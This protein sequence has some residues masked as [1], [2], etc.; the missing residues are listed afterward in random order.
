MTGLEVAKQR[1]WS[2]VSATKPSKHSQWHISP[3]ST[4][5]VVSKSQPWL[6]SSQGCSVGMCEGDIVGASL[7]GSNEGAVDGS[8]VGSCVGRSVGDEVN[9][10]LVS[11]YSS[12][13]KPSKHS[14]WHMSPSFTVIV[15]SKSQ[16]CEPV[17]QGCGV[18]MCVGVVVGATL[19]GANVGSELGSVDGCAVGSAVGLE[20]AT[21]CVVSLESIV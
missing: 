17:S 7:V 21:Q 5:I 9:M 20:V 3:S 14:Q 13:I 18:G 10:H 12:A 1:V 16:P 6:P 19:V 4:A 2:L 8:S 11:S 15:V